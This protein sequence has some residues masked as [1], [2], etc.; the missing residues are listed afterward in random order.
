MTFGLGRKPS[1]KDDRDYKLADYLP[2]EAAASMFWQTGT[3][4]DQGQTGHCV[5][6]GFADFGNCLPVDDNY[7]NSDG[8]AIYYEAKVIDGEPNQEDGSTVR[9]GAKAM[10]NRGRIGAYAFGSPAEAKAFVLS[11]G[12]VTLGIDWYDGMFNPDASGVIRPTGNLAGGHCILCYG[13]DATYAYLQN[14]W[15]ASWGVKGCC[16]IS[17]A[18]L[19]SIFADGGEACAAVELP[20]PAPPAPDPTPTPTPT[21]TPVPPAPPKPPAGAWAWFKALVAWLDHWFF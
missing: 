12:P 21:P 10:K 5:G 7:A 9:S 13:A 1:P 20:L 19:S 8:H 11:K 6:F 2:A 3:M 17:W 16:K 15:G 18:D 14:S 4:L